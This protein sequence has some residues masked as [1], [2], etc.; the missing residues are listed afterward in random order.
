MILCSLSGP[1]KDLGLKWFVPNDL[2][3][4][5]YMLLF[6]KLGDFFY[7]TFEA[8]VVGRL[9]I[10]KAQGIP[11]KPASLAPALGGGGLER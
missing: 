5:L 9:Q 6:S 8:L 11:P 3:I 2:N 7:A 1:V 10:C 4:K